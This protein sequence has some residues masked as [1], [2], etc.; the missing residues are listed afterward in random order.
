[1]AKRRTY[2]TNAS[3]QARIL[4]GAL[5]E[6][7]PPPN[8]PLEQ[9]DRLFFDNV[10]AE[11]TRGEWSQHQLELAA[12]LARCM[13]DLEREQVLLRDEGSIMR[14]DKGTPVVNPRRSVVQMLTGAIFNFRRSLSLH[15]RAQLGEPRD[16]GKRRGRIQEIVADNPLADDLLAHPN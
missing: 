16:V 4:S 8:V 9:G 3:E 13:A 11:F 2:I 14:T 7:E 5:R 10:I 6:L 12:M 15:A 1:M